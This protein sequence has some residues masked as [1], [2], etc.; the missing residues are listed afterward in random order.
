MTHRFHHP[1]RHRATG[2]TLL[3][4]LIVLAILGLLAALVVPKL[5][6]KVVDAQVRTTEV[7]IVSL[8]NALEQFAI[9]VGR[10][11]STAEGLGALVTEPSG[12]PS[13]LWNGPYLQQNVVPTDSWKNAFVYENNN[14]QY[15]IRSLGADAALGGTG[16][17]ADLDN[18]GS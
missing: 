5:G 17:N 9:D 8:S 7:Q 10:Y 4:L 11:P 14:G 15:L 16:A 2:F 6:G 13:G 1:S 12:L 18:L 3:E